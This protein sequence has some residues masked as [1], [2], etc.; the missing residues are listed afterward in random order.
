MKSASKRIDA[1]DKW[2]E[3]GPAPEADPVPPH[4]AIRLALAVGLAIAQ[5][6]HEVAGE[7]SDVADAIRESR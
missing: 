6:I 4:R 1:M 3:A 7:V 5:A 2:L